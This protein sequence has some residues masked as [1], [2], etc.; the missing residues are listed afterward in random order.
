MTKKEFLNG[1]KLILHFMGFKF[2]NDDK[3]AFNEGYFYLDHEG[4]RNIVTLKECDYE[5]SFNS[6]MPVVY[7]C[8]Y[9]ISEQGF[10]GHTIDELYAKKIYTTHL[11]NSIESVWKCVIEFI[12]WHNK[13][14]RL[15]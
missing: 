7:K 2:C 5:E 4:E 15:C 8:C 6:I 14:I 1:N 10:V 11:N 3:K 12:K 13:Q 9:K